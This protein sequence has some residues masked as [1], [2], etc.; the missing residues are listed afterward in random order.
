[1][2][3]AATPHRLARFDFCVPRY[4]FHLFDDLTVIDEEGVELPSPAAAREH[5]IANART[6]ACAELTEGHLNLK[7]RIEVTDES[8]ST[9]LT[10]RFA[11]AFE[12]ES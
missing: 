4:F 10:L 1:M 12:L 8:A 9:I 5:A 7:H 3:R 6:M 11:D 2:L